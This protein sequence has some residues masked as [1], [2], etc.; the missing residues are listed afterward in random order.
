MGERITL[1][2]V[3]TRHALYKMCSITI[4]FIIIFI[5]NLRSII[6]VCTCITM[7]FQEFIQVISLQSLLFNEFF[8]LVISFGGA[9]FGLNFNQEIIL[10]CLLQH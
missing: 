1:L 7:K 9:Y 3:F 10:A 5:I 6:N 2:L 4:L 8:S